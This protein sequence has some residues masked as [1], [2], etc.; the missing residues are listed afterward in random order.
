MTCQREPRP[1]RPSTRPCCLSSCDVLVVTELDRLARAGC[2]A[3]PVF[4]RLP[5]SRP[6]SELARLDPAYE[7]PALT[8]AVG[9]SASS[10]YV[11]GEPPPRRSPPGGRSDEAPRDA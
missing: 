3:I 9:R 11:S 2:Q 5:G 7:G 10:R 6:R 1:T 8:G 4:T